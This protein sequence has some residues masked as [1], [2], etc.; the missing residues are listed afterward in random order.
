MNLK[1]LAWLGL[2]AAVLVALGVAA[3]VVPQW[4]LMK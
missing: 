2:G 3:A 4:F 1:V